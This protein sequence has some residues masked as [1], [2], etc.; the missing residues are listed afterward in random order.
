MPIIPRQLRTIRIRDWHFK[1]SDKWGRLRYIF[2]YVKTEMQQGN[3]AAWIL[4]QAIGR[5]NQRSRLS[6]T[7]NLCFCYST[8]HAIQNIAD[9]HKK[10]QNTC[11][12]PGIFAH[13]L[14]GFVDSL[15]FRSA[16][17]T[18]ANVLIFII[19]NAC[20]GYRITVWI[21]HL[22]P[23]DLTPFVRR[24]I[25]ELDG[26][27]SVQYIDDGM[28]FL[29]RDTLIYQRGYISSTAQIH[30]WDFMA[31][32]SEAGFPPTAVRSHFQRAIEVVRTTYPFLLNQ[33]LRQ[34]GQQMHQ[35]GEI[36]VSLVLSSKLIDVDFCLRSLVLCYPPC[37]AFYI[38]H[39]NASKNHSQL[40]LTL[41]KLP[42]E[43]P[44]F[45][46]LGIA[47]QLP[48]R[49][50]FGLTSSIVILIEMLLRLNSR[51]DV[52]L[53]YAGHDG[54]QDTC[55]GQLMH[56]KKLLIHYQQLSAVREKGIN[57]VI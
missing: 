41:H 38:P 35:K 36:P 19:A 43:M 48:C 32:P 17:S 8:L 56:F 45:G 14:L 39:Y 30:S 49:I 52:V 22:G 4:A 31:L 25:G 57:I 54:R 23:E 5:A 20:R 2:V 13:S 51:V 55:S 16:P 37:Q 34:L 9:P 28:G 1:P 7:K 12:F 6:K 21:P 3:F 15:G 44:E 10:R 26:F 47:E 50:F 40:D 11:F 46:L 53:V 33:G 24:L 42:L 29:S 18:G 27:Q